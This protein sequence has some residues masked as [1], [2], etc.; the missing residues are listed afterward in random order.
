MSL[1]QD[2]HATSERSQRHA[3][4]LQAAVPDAERALQVMNI[5]PGI[6]MHVTAH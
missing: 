6:D 1:L 4:A 5:L 2:A 3:N